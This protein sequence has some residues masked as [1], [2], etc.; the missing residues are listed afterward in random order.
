MS[1]VSGRDEARQRREQARR[2]RRDS[3]P[4]QEPENAA[5]EPEDGADPGGGQGSSLLGAAGVAAAGAAVGAALGAARALTERDGRGESNGEPHDS[6]GAEQPRP[7][8][9]PEPDRAE[10]DESESEPEPWAEP[11]ATSSA[12]P[13]LPPPEPVEGASPDETAEVVRRARAQLQALHGSE[14][15]SI[16]SLERTP[17]GWRATFEVIELRRVPD[18]TDVLASYEVVLDDRLNV[19]RYAR[20]RRYY[21]AQADHEER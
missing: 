9:A 1:P 10:A 6:P 16:S 14:P 11:E 4:Q 17:E 15:E 5:P 12:S 20:V 19:T 2:Q 7:E 13:Q 3:Q 21:R 18:S 8:P